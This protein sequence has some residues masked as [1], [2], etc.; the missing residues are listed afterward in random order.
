LI[1]PQHPS[2]Q[3]EDNWGAHVK[4]VTTY[5]VDTSDS[6]G[7]PKLDDDHTL[8]ETQRKI[9]IPGSIDPLVNVLNAGRHDLMS[10]L[11][12]FGDLG[13][14]KLPSHGSG[15]GSGGHPDGSRLE[16]IGNMGKFTGLAESLRASFGPGGEGR[17][18]DT[19]RPDSDLSVDNTDQ[20]KDGGLR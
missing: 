20:S 11:I 8:A 12:E 18:P 1:A 15:S 10:S 16:G 13:L 9:I 5:W 6:D 2:G 3:D 19:F 17:M 7:A 4:K 14:A